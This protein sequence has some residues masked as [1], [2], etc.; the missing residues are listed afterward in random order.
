MY[1]ITNYSPA[2][3][4]LILDGTKANAVDMLRFTLMDL[5]FR[6]ILR[7]QPEDKDS[8]KYIS[9]N[10]V[11][12]LTNL[13]SH[14]RIFTDIFDKD[15]S[16][17][18]EIGRYIKA[19]NDEVKNKSFYKFYISKNSSV[20]QLFKHNLVQ[21]MLNDFS[22][23]QEGKKAR[24]KLMSIINSLE[25]ELPPLIKNQSAQSV[26]IIKRLGGNLFLLKGIDYK[27]IGEIPE[28]IWVQEHSRDKENQVLNT[29]GPM[30]DVILL[31]DLFEAIEQSSDDDSGCF[32]DSGDSG[33]GGGDGGCSGCGG[34]GG[35]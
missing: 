32:A 31:F 8:A 28:I 3:N 21:E 26:E 33:D 4:L 18:I 17:K 1:K 16:H 15:V 29:S 23:T 9:L 25:K 35:D 22:F 5:L 14:E 19:C 7:I 24:E 13:K 30:V 20:K 6:G 34:C 12:P 11:T 10:L 27:T 2:E